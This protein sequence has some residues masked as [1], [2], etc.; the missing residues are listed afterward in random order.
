M[1]STPAGVLPNK[2]LAKSLIILSVLH[3]FLAQAL[4]Q[5]DLI[6]GM[7]GISRYTHVIDFA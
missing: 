4:D 7:K 1:V 2:A 3:D 6:P 5:P